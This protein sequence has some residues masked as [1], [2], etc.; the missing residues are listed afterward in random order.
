MTAFAAILHKDDDPPYI[1]GIAAE[2]SA[3]TG[4]PATAAAHGRCALI[5]APM[6]ADDEP[7]P[8]ERPNHVAV[9][10]SLVVEGGIGRFRGDSDRLTGEYA[11]AAWDRKQER[12]LCARD[13]LGIRCVYVAAAP[14]AIVVTNVL[15]AA[16]RHPRIAAALDDAALLAFLAHGGAPDDVRTCYRDIRMLPPGHT[17]AIDGRTF[18]SRMWRHWHFPLADGRRRTDAAILEEYRAVLAEAVRDRL[19][20]RGTTIFLSGGIDSTTMAAAAVDAAPA[21]TLR[22]ITTRYPRYV[23]DVELPFTRAAA[24]CLGLPLIVVNAD[25]HVPWQVDPADL[26]PASPLDEPMLADWR[27][28]LARAAE[29][30]SVALY[31]EDGDA[32]FR[33]PGWRALRRSASL[34]T[35]AASVA[36]YV[37]AERRRPYLGLRWRERTGIVRPRMHAPPV[38]LNAEGRALLDRREPATVLGCAP[39]PLPPH[40]T[41]PEAQ[42]ILTSTTVSR[43]FAATIAPET[44]RRR[45]ELR[46]PILD[47]RV[48]QLVMSVPAIP[49]C[50]RKALPRRAYRGRLPREVLARPKTPL[51]GFNE[52]LVA[53]WR[54]ASGDRIMPPGEPVARWIDVGTWTRTLRQG[55]PD[56]VMAAWRVSALDAWIASGARAAGEAACIR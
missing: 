2:L 31:G 13:G 18:A 33:P 37:A 4:R 26:P 12:L 55:A 19:D 45:V 50:Q 47:T 49:W 54:A 5:A 6:H 23:D 30:G 46:L 34:I 16:L 29:H 32:L 28:A 11:F 39:E 43:T 38:W 51:V 3:L 10:G 15:A 25:A 20:P 53:A 27:D 35:I 9:A 44:T 7:V 22:A 40:P 52:A 8:V 48:I 36:R 56:A 14:E 24:D 21:D 1:E 17:L 41:R 42:A